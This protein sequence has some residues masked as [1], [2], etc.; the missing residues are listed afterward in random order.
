MAEAVYENGMRWKNLPVAKNSNNYKPQR[1]KRPRKSEPDEYLYSRVNYSLGHRFCRAWLLL[2]I[3]LEW[4]Y[5][6]GFLM[7]NR[8]SDELSPYLL[9]HASNPVDWRPWGEEALGAARQEQNPIFLV[10]RLFVVP[11]VPRDGPREFRECQNR[12]C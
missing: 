4:P 10:D 1:K 8:L 6:R 12:R 9:Q 3:R 11:L 2:P 7:T 5:G